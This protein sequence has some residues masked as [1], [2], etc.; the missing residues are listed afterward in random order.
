MSHFS[1]VKTLI[2]DRQALV[3]ALTELKLEPQVFEQP[4]ALQGYYGKRDGNYSAE[5]V[6]AGKSIKARADIGFRW[7]EQSRVYDVIQDE[8][9]TRPRLG[10]DF[11]TNKLMHAYGNQVVRA[12]AAELSERLGNCTIT[13]SSNGSLQTLRLTFAAHQQI[14]QTRR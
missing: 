4:Q 2:R 11:F 3:A 9:E 12:K 10:H 7:N 14:Q 13:E 6:V 5:I 8:Y 1:Q